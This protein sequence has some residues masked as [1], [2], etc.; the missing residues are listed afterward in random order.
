MFLF[1]QILPRTVVVAILLTQAMTQ[2]GEVTVTSTT[3]TTTAP[4]STVAVSYAYGLSLLAIEGFTVSGES[5][6]GY[7][8]PHTTTS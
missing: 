8:D 3:T 2:K 5:T 4:F 6:C 7:L 1:L